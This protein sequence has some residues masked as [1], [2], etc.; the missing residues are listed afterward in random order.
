MICEECTELFVTTMMQ[1]YLKNL[2]EADCRASQLRVL[3]QGPPVYVSVSTLFYVLHRINLCSL[4]LM[5]SM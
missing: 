4:F 1:T 2:L 5:E 3:A